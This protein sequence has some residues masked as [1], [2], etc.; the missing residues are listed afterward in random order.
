MCGASSAVADQPSFTC[1]QQGARERLAQQELQIKDR[2]TA[3]YACVDDAAKAAHPSSC[4]GALSRQRSDR[5]YTIDLLRAQEETSA[6]A[7]EQCNINYRA[8]LHLTQQ[9]N[10]LNTDLK[11]AKDGQVAVGFFSAAL[12]AV[13]TGAVVAAAGSSSGRKRGG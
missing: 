12:A 11:S 13:A 5:T 4:P 7:V 3:T 1:Y 2:G 10:A 8:V 9:V 6:K